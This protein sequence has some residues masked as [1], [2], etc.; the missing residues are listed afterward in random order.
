[1]NKPP[2]DVEAVAKSVIGMAEAEAVQTLNEAGLTSRVV[3][4]DGED[5]PATK[6]YSPTRVNLWIEN[7][8]VTKTT[9][10]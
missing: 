8:I 1:M 2:S 7:D 4:R 5:Y 6:D 9:V 3:F 10:G